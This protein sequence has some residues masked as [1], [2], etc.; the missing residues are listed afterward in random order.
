HIGVQDAPSEMFGKVMS[1]SDALMWRYYELLTE[2]D[3]E[4]AKQLHPMEAKKRLAAAIVARFHGAAAGQEARAGFESVFSKKEEPED[5]EEFRMNAPMDIV[6]LMIAADLAPS[7]NE[8]RRLLEQ[9]GVQL[10][11]RRVAA[12]E[13]ISLN[14][15]AVIK[16]GKRRFKKLLP[17]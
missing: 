12:G 14:E 16:V 8:A 2:E 10:A 17:A 11:G 4:A 13:K 7:K 3:L 6:D 5:L 1:V 9:G 15:P